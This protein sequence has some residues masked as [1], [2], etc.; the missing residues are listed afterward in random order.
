LYS[1]QH[2]VRASD[3]DESGR[4]EQQKLHPASGDDD[5]DDAL[6]YDEMGESGLHP[7]IHG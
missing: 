3:F 1:F 6:D 5:G 2:K 7:E 4:Q